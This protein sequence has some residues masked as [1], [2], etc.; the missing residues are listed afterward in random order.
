MILPR[1]QTKFKILQN[2][3]KMTM[4]RRLRCLGTTN[5]R[6]EEKI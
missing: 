6:L 5:L 1:F 2:M 4:K 3:K